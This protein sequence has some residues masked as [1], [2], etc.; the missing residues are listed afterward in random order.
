LGDEALSQI[1]LNFISMIPVLDKG[2]ENVSKE[3][4][5]QD[6][7]KSDIQLRFEAFHRLNPHVLD[8]VI[9]LAQRTK[10][11]GRTRGSIS[12]IFEVLRYSYALRTAGDD[13]KL[14]NAH[15]AFYARLVMSV[16][17]ELS[18]GKPFFLLSSQRSPYIIDW[19]SLEI[20]N[21][22]W[23]SYNWKLPAQ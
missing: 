6:G 4:I 22:G 9:D 3:H 11:A 18:N 7:L 15:R 14:A 8:A 19:A 21:K 13:Y 1:E 17:P 2:I 10:K 5:K 20:E 16:V 23:I 12:Q